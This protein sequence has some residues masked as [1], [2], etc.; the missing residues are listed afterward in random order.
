MSLELVPVTLTD[1]RRL[2][3]ELHRHNK[4]PL[5]WLFGTGVANGHGLAGAAIVSRPVAPGLQDGRTVEIIRVVT[6]GTRNANSKLYG[7]ACRMA[8]AG[9]YRGA[10]T[11]TLESE[12]GASLKAAGF[13]AEAM[14]PERD[15]SEES[16]RDRY[17][18]NL[19][20]E[21]SSPPGNRIRWR[22]ML[23]DTQRED[24]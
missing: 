11:Y 10:V 18:E 17:Q 24:G 13:V 9:G 4:P 19:F 3:A 5:G 22:R 7:A 15:W 12:S 2:V 20:G 16:G 23:A 1:A 8:A 6:D 21:R 14:L